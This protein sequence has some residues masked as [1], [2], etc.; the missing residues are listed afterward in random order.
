MDVIK[1]I[2]DSNTMRRLS[3]APFYEQL[4]TLNRRSEELKWVKMTYDGLVVAYTPWV[5][6]P[7]GEGRDRLSNS[8]ATE[9]IRDIE[10]F[11][12]EAK[13]NEMINKT[14]K[15][16][17]D[18]AIHRARRQYSTDLLLFLNN[19]TMLQEEVGITDRKDSH[20]KAV[21]KEAMRLININIYLARK[22]VTFMETNRVT[23][24]TRLVGN[25]IKIAEQQAPGRA[26]LRTEELSAIT[27][28]EVTKTEIMVIKGRV[29]IQI[30]VPI[31]E[32]KSY[33]MYQMTP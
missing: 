21:L 6:T 23:Q 24:P 19:L 17:M 26:P 33:R 30:T 9:I 16:I 4:F 15:I 2:T 14:Q 5:E 18:N 8:V 7:H 3:D 29:V 28:A 22:I 10:Q 20:I 27:L 11:R 31:L 1:N 13:E 12:R 25:A 32:T